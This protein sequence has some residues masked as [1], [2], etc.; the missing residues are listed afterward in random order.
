M[1][2][3]LG[4]K[5]EQSRRTAPVHRYIWYGRYGAFFNDAW[6][7]DHWPKWLV[8][9]NPS[10]KYRE[11]V[12][13]YLALKIWGPDIRKKR[14]ILHSNNLGV[15]QAWAAHRSICLGILDLMRRIK[16]ISG[17]N[18]DIADELSRLQGS[19]F[20]TLVPYA[21]LEPVHIPESF[22]D[23]EAAFTDQWKKQCLY[24]RRP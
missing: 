1:L 3:L 18:N 21:A 20:R 7:Q 4:C 16:H 9:R 13:I 19:R 22:L 15:V 24:P 2:I 11:L 8:Y 17:C 23:L 12:P 10:K 14:I 6:F 5:L